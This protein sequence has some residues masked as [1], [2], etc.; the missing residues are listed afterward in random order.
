[1]KFLLIGLVRLYQLFLSPLLRMMNGGHG[2]CRHQ[3]SCSN[4][5]IESFQL[6]GVIKGSFL[7]TKRLLRCHPWGTYGHDPVPPL[8]KTHPS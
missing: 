5:A 2:N 7:T 8:K 3:P 1:M 4:Y 6:H